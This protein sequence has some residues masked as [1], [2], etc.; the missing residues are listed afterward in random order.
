MTF[1]IVFLLQIVFK[2]EIRYVVQ[3]FTYES[4]FI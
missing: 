1:I 2:I 3:S 4:E